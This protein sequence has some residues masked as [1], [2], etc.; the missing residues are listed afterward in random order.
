MNHPASAAIL[1]RARRVTPG[2]VNT[3]IRRVDPMPIWSRAA[4]SRVY[5]VQG[6]EYIDYH[7]A[8][9]PAILG[10]CHA[11]VNRCVRETLDEIDL[12]GVG[13]TER[14]I[15]LAEKIVQHV[16]S[17]EMALLCNTGSEATHHAV[18]LSRAVTGRRK[19]IKFQGCYHGWHDYLCMNV[20]TPRDKI[21]AHDPGS[22]GMLRE[23]VENTIVLPFNDLDAV[24][25][26]L[27]RN[28]GQ[29]AGLI[30]EPIPHNIGCVL[31]RPGYLEGLR[32]MTRQHGVILTFDEVITGFRHTIGGYQKVSGVTPDLTTLGKSIA[33]GYPI[34]AICGRRDLM[35]RF[36]TREGGD[37]FF[38]G[39]YNG[40]PINCAAALATIAEL[41]D[42]RV[43]G[44]I[45]RL[46]ERMRRGLREIVARSGIE[47][48]VAGFG[49]VFLTYFLEGPV[50]SYEDL[51]DND[52]RRQVRY[53][54]LLLDR[55]IF[56]LPMSLKRSHIG[57]AH[58]EED[59]DRTLSAAEDA[60]RR[61]VHGESRPVALQ[62][63]G[64]ESGEPK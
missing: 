12:L 39:T 11:G 28:R 25:Q 60:F 4:G 37:V 51:L 16:P 1:E 44:H 27:E 15:R 42:G 22:A 52:D 47:A 7:A 36:A 64:T 50:H 43:H 46:G 30:L 63:V 23:A 26:A 2:G 31:P 41:E 24:A 45:F 48:H 40:H 19:F 6:R 38:A 14:E 20:I 21:G 57:A 58:T 56:K 3:S 54:Q 55:G 9:G 33:N 32:E 18:R 10:H 8:F 13:T 62:S 17:A 34:A 35:E 59:I 5:D 53:R 49:S 29:V 61:L